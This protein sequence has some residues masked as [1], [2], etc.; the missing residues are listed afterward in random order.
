MF[1][2]LWR[3][4]DFT[5]DRFVPS[6][7]HYEYE[8]TNS[9]H[10][11]EARSCGLSVS[12]CIT[13]CTCAARQYAPS[14]LIPPKMVRFPV[15]IPKACLKIL[16]WLTLEPINASLDIDLTSYAYLKPREFL[17]VEGKARR[18][19]RTKVSMRTL[20]GTLAMPFGDQGTRHCEEWR[21]NLWTYVWY[22]S[23]LSLLKE[24]IW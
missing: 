18:S 8:W 5:N 13:G 4:T 2:A 1:L 3:S 6:P 24:E 16:S 14:V 11:T 17:Q 12:C 10:T 22:W 20:S 9:P 19:Y 23:F 7:G 21:W 15:M